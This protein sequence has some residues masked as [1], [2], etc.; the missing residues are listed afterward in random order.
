[1][2]ASLARAQSIADLRL[3]ARR[4]LPRAVFDF[5]DGA[6]EDESALRANA[7]AFEAARLLPRVLR[8]VSAVDASAQLLGAPAALPMAVAPM[9]AIGLGWRG[10]D[11]AVARAAAAAGIPYTLSSAAH[12]SIEEIA[13]A[14]PGRLWFQPYML[15]Q[16]EFV[17]RWIERARAAD[18]EALVVT[19]DLP[20]GGKRERDARN[21]FTLPFRL[22]PRN[23]LDFA[24]RPRWSLEMLLRGQPVMQN[25]V[26][27]EQ[28]P[29]TTTAMASTVGRNMDA[30]F[31]EDD[32]RRIRDRWP[33]KLI[34]KGILRPDDALRVAALGADAVVVSNHGGRQLDA[35][36]ATLRALPAVVAAVQGRIE[37]LVDGGVRRGRHLA[38][39]RACGASGVLLGRAMLYG[40]AAAGEAGAR[41]ALDLLRDEF[42]RT[43]RLCGARHVGELDRGLLAASLAE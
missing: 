18:Y 16:R 31:G 25:M 36:E 39:A 8:D 3:A 30:S 4:R 19:V 32:L 10:A 14:A 21:H 34:V 41:H 20:V 37:V 23:V 5:F 11:V 15:R 27:L 22:T 9:G 12:A 42:I 28:G 1:M 33:R 6:A 7:A 35:A 17:H 2:A 13:R 26:G 40:V 38:V 43:M 24:A 29:A